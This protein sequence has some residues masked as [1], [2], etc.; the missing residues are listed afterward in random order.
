MVANVERFIA[1]YAQ[2]K[3]NDRLIIGLIYVTVRYS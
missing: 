1:L 2:F 3:D